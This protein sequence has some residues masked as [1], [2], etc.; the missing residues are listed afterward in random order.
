MIKRQTMTQLSADAI[1]GTSL[2][3]LARFWRFSTLLPTYTVEVIGTGSGNRIG[4]LQIAS[5]KMLC[6]CACECAILVSRHTQLIAVGMIA[7]AGWM[8]LSYRYSLL[9]TRYSVLAS[10]RCSPRRCSDH[11]QTLCRHQECL[12][13]LSDAV[14]NRNPSASFF[15]SPRPLLH[16]AATNDQWRVAEMGFTQTRSSSARVTLQLSAQARLVLAPPL[17]RQPAVIMQQ[18]GH[19]HWILSTS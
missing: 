2:L 17:G 13:V 9:A 10:C 7:V 5:Q 15:S 8:L 4:K 19:R 1:P 12:H 14:T 18:V 3:A 6:A 11:S 16:Q